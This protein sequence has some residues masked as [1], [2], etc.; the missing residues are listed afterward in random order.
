MSD[1]AAE[2]G[3]RH[4]GPILVE[5]AQTDA[6]GD[7][8]RNDH[9]V[10]AATGQAGHQRRSKQKNEDRVP[11]LAKEDGTGTH[12]T[13]AEGVWPELSQA[14]GH[15]VGREPIRATAQTRKHVVGRKT[16]GVDQV[17]RIQLGAHDDHGSS[18]T[19]GTQCR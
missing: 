9:R 5:E 11:D 18:F 3:H 7:D 19:V 15:I 1:L 8:H 4:F 10:R 6:E 2:G 17:R 13:R 14:F 16:G 12:L